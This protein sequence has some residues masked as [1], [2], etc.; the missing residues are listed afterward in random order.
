MGKPVA[1]PLQ[2]LVPPWQR[3]A[4]DAALPP[5][6]PPWSSHLPAQACRVPPS[7]PCLGCQDLPGGN[8]TLRGLVPMDGR[9]ASCP[10]GCSTVTGREP[11]PRRCDTDEFFCVPKQGLIIQATELEPREAAKLNETG[12]T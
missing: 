1:V 8:E 10:Q 3:A 9:W 12:S 5:Q 6:V 11:C 2:T 4:A 7:A